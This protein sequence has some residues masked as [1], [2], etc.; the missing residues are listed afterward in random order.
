MSFRKGIGGRLRAGNK[1]GKSGFGA[2]QGGKAQRWANT[3]PTAYW[4]VEGIADDATTL[5]DKSKKGLGLNGTLG[6]TVSEVAGNAKTWNT[7]QTPNGSSQS[8][9]FN[10]TNNAVVIPYNSALKP[11]AT[12]LSFSIWFKTTA[13]DLYL[14][15]TENENADPGWRG[16]WVYV[17][18]SAG[19]EGAA[20]PLVVNYITTDN[21]A[22]RSTNTT[23]NDGEWH[24][25]VFVYDESAENSIV[26]YQDGEVVL[27]NN[28]QGGGWGAAGDNTVGIQLG[29]RKN[30]QYFKYYMDEIGYF[31]DIGL[32]AKQVKDMYN[33]GK[34]VNSYAGILKG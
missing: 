17:A 8:L 25:S 4:R 11:T 26:I 2:S 13:N 29:K 31:T 33:G 1:L 15:V 6:G 12:K 5:P 7:A 19:G 14:L 16:G 21:T 9:Y 27:A 24:H 34:V 10:G 18:I 30:T 22:W 3:V 20:K 32:T 28:L 23:A